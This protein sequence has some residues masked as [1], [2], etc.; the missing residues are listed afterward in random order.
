MKRIKKKVTQAISYKLELTTDLSV[1]LDEQSLKEDKTFY[2]VVID[3]AQ[4]VM[5]D[6]DL[7]DK[8]YQVR[9]VSEVREGE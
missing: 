8:V 4:E 1:T 9:V 3:K 6:T 5:N 7:N 2:E